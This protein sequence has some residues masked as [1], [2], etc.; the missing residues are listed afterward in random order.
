MKRIY[1]LSLCLTVFQSCEEIMPSAPANNEVLDGPI[2]GLSAAQLRVFLAGDEKFSEVFT[3]ETGLGPYFV[4]SSCVSCHPGDGKGHPSSGL[5]RFGKFT[6]G[7]FDHMLDQ[8]GPQLQ[9]RAIP[10]FE[11]EI[12]PSDATGVT[13]FLA[14][15]V[16][17]L[18]LLE[19]VSD[20]DILAHADPTDLDGDG[21][22]GVPN[23]IEAPDF[24]EPRSFHIANG[25]SYIGRFGKKA[26]AIDL[27]MQTVGAYK[28]DMGI[29]SDFDLEDPINYNDSDIAIGSVG[30]PEV[31]A[32]TVNEVV[33]YLSTLKP[34]VRRNI[35]HPNVVNGE[36][37]FDQIG[38]TSCHMPTLKTGD[39][40]VAA[41][42][43]QTFHPYTD[44]LM[45]DMGF[46]LDDGYTEGTATTSEWKTPALWGLGL[47]KDA[48]GGSYFLLHDG[49]A[50]SIEDAIFMH[51]G[52]AAQSAANFSELSEE[53][54]AFVIQFL[55]SL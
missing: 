15:A 39:H 49:R 13:T 8:G 40:A 54:R 30:D 29:T 26:G 5:T 55:E 24:F 37:L 2:E 32:G 11:A 42:A 1:L 20:A 22:S 31:S 23:Y 46:A 47:S 10:G 36:V 33:F 53:N 43:N 45:H 7:S 16:T 14:P 34:P 21:I 17:G 44:L 35:K 18:G 3:P 50:R 25:T 52:E 19:A 6:S 27:K 51:G 4:T 48:Q 41:L 9:N 38:C 28:Q 12:V